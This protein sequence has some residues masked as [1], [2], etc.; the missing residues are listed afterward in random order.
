MPNELPSMLES[1]ILGW[2]EYGDTLIFL[3]KLIVISFPDSLVLFLL[4]FFFL[5]SFIIISNCL[6]F[7]FM[8]FLHSLLLPSY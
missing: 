2:E 3:F 4:F 6:P 8:K 7:S 1:T 5:Y